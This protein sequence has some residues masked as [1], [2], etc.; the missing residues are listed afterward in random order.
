MHNKKAPQIRRAGA[1]AK[2]RG[3]SSPSN[4]VTG[5]AYHDQNTSKNAENDIEVVSDAIWLSPSHGRE[6]VKC[7]SGIGKKNYGETD[8]PEYLQKPPHLPASAVP[9]TRGGYAAA[10]SG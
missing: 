3:A 8:G 9:A 1:V 7:S 2:S 10:G 4:P 6:E 5:Q